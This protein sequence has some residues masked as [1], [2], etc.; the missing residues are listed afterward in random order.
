M[1]IYIYILHRALL[2]TTTGKP[3]YIYMSS[4]SSA[5]NISVLWLKGEFGITPRSDHSPAQY[6]HTCSYIRWERQTVD[7][8]THFYMWVRVYRA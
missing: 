4:L 3:Y 6:I 1:Y 2:F 8:F 5:E 7:M